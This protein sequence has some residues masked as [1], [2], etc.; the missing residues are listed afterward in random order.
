MNGLAR[1]IVVTL[2]MTTSA[3]AQSPGR[4]PAQTDEAPP[5]SPTMDAFDLWRHIRGKAPSPQAGSDD[6]RQS[7]KAFAPVIGAKPTSGVLVGVAGNVAFY[8]G[9]PSTT[10]LSSLVTSFTFS[11]EKQ[12]ALTDRFTL[13]ARN[14]GWRLEGD[15]RFQW[16]SLNTYALGTSA[17]TRTGTEARFDFF[18]LHH[19]AYYRL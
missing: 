12:T 8:R 6:Y 9:D 13:F 11:T 7:M 14:D 10:H 2:L 1:F 16:T 19:T 18:R 5:P 17:D 4:D 15:H 3:T